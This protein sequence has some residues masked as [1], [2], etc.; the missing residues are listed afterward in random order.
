MG[1]FSCSDSTS[2]DKDNDVT[3]PTE[4]P[5]EP[6][7]TKNNKHPFLIVTQ[8]MY[9]ALREKASQEPWKSMKAD[10]VIRSKQV[11]INPSTV[12][13]NEYVG[14]AALAYILDEAKSKSH[15]LRVRNAIINHHSK[16]KLAP[17]DWG[18]VVPPM[19]ALFTAILALDIVYDAL[20]EED[21]AQCEEIIESQISKLSINNDQAARGA[22]GTWEIYKGKRT[23]PDDIYYD[24]IMNQITPDGV[25]PV[26]PTY[27]WAR[28]GGGNSEVS[29]SGY[30]DVLEF[31]GVDKRFYNNERIKKFQRWLYGSSVNC[32]KDYIII[33]DMLPTAKVGPSL[34]HWRIV[35]FDSEAAGYAAWLYEGRTPPGHILSYI[36]P[37]SKLPSPVVPSS[38]LYEN[39]GAFLR[40][41]EDD[42]N[43]LQLTLYNI[44]TQD[45]WHTHNEVNGLSLSGL[46][47]RL[48]VNGG[49]L[50]APVRAANLNNTLTINGENHI[51]RLGG[52]IV[53]GFTSDVLD[54][55]IGS[56]G[57]ALSSAFHL[58]NTILVHTTP[59]TP[60]YFIIFDEVEAKWGQKIKKYLHPANESTVDVVAPLTEYTAE[61]DHYPTVGNVS[62]SF[63]YL[64]PPNEVNVEKV[65]SAVPDRYPNYPDHNRLESVY[66]V[67]VYGNKN[68]TTVIY[69]FLTNANLTKAKLEKIEGENMNACTV[70]YGNVTDYIFEITPGREVNSSG[71]NIRGDLSLIRKIGDKPSFYFVKNGNYLISESFGFKSDRMVTVYTDGKKGTIIS[72]G[73]KVKLMG[74]GMGK[75]KFSSLV[76]VISSGTDFIEVQLEKGTFKFE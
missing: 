38:K 63:Y 54:F 39:G 48:L 56:S 9:P 53:G 34:L 2:F 20:T 6:D 62:A 14:A 60:G 5:N 44:K 55:A 24:L 18:T 73:A 64:T 59:N 75:A 8:D 58:R 10:A 45:E 32:A 28:I 50:G 23:T 4:K 40:D 42:P 49:R 26:T 29:K 1:V 69:P 16:L 70:S 21:I 37:K 68:L 46:G 52:G 30:M 76:E 3:P 67:D 47:N 57:P 22:H 36:L 7:G 61:I 41:K 13:L 66:D 19:G 65:K 71:M 17:G 33:G 15:A 25:S 11:I 27:G 72:E 12:Q 31:T 74:V 35:N 43:G 51:S